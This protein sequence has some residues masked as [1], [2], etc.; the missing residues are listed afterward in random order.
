[1]TNP[2]KSY[3][4]IQLKQYNTV[5]VEFNGLLLS[6]KISDMCISD[7]SVCVLILAI[8]LSDGT[9]PAI[10]YQDLELWRL[11]LHTRSGWDNPGMLKSS[12]PAHCWSQGS[13]I[14]TSSTGYHYVCLSRSASPL[15]IF[16]VP[17]RTVQCYTQSLFQ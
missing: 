13:L 4:C 5:T 6:D 9:G 8:S 17:L 3:Y 1:M 2:Q 14:K 7:W 11:L 16:K 10:T 15:S 12:Q